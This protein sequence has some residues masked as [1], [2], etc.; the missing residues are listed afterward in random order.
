[1]QKPQRIVLANLLLHTRREWYPQQKL[2]VLQ[3]GLP[4]PVESSPYPIN[5]MSLASQG[6]TSNP[7]P[8]LVC[9]EKDSANLTF[10]F[11]DDAH[12]CQCEVAYPLLRFTLA[13]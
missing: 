3:I 2:G 7:H 4:I 6:V 12:S 9:T 13:C 1:M 8:A 11:E 10:I 5:P